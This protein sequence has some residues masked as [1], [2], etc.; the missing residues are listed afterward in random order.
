MDATYTPQHSNESPIIPGSWCNCF[1]TFN[2]W[3]RADDTSWQAFDLASRPGLNLA[4]FLSVAHKCWSSQ[5]WHTHIGPDDRDGTQGAG[6]FSWS[7]PHPPHPPH[8]PPPPLWRSRTQQL[9]EGFTV[10]WLT[11]WVAQNDNIAGARNTRVQLRALAMLSLC[12]TRHV[13]Q[14][15]VKAKRFV[16]SRDIGQPSSHKGKRGPTKLLCALWTVVTANAS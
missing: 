6:E 16:T 10:Y 13:C 5:T 9:E 14:Y 2:A 15:I 11:W 7:S 1:S 12:S 4:L 3:R 8:P